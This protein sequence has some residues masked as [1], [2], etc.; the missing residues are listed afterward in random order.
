MA[1]TPIRRGVVQRVVADGVILYAEDDSCALFVPFDQVD[2][3]KA[4][5]DGERKAQVREGRRRMA[6]L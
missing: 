4:V 6:A 3:A 5:A 1:H 2:A